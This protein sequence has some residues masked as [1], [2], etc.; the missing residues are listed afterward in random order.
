MEQDSESIV[1]RE[2]NMN[3]CLE[4]LAQLMHSDTHQV[5]RTRSTSL[6]SKNHVETKS[7]KRRKSDALDGISKLKCFQSEIF[8]CIRECLGVGDNNVV[9]DNCLLLYGLPQENIDVA[10]AEATLKQMFGIDF[11]ISLRSSTL[12]ASLTSG[13]SWVTLFG[14]G[15]LIHDILGSPKSGFGL[16]FNHEFAKYLLNYNDALV[17][18]LNQF[19][20]SVDN[21]TCYAWRSYDEDQ[22]KLTKSSTLRERFSDAPVSKKLLSDS[23]RSY[24]KT[25][26]IVREEKVEADVYNL[27]RRPEMAESIT[28]SIWDVCPAIYDYLKRIVANNNQKAFDY[29]IAWL[30]K[31]WKHGQSQKDL[32]LLSS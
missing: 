15:G 16:K 5:Y 27:Y 28:G 2:E 24:I 13:D 23:K 3:D 25:D 20:F 32:V 7:N 29:I 8:D 12:S 21:P 22:F 4:K 9:H 1:I 6:P 17:Q 26:F 19:M 14:E 10:A 30:T 31:M 18:Y 11:K